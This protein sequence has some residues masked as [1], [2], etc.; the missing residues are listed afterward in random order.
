MYINYE[1]KIYKVVEE[2]VQLDKEQYKL[3][4]WESAVQ[5]DK[6]EI[7]EYNAKIAE[8]EAFDIPPEYKATLKESVTLS[9]PSG[10]KESMV[11]TQRAIVEE[12][13]SL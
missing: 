13:K 7:D 6:R 9:S 2:D 1:G 3:E 12:I 11:D 5:N 10:I 4:A 8:I